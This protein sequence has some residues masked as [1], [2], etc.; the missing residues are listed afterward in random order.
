VI[1]FRKGFVCS[2]C[3]GHAQMPQGE[4]RRCY[5]FL[6]SD[7][8]FAHCTRIECGPIEKC[9]TYAHRIGGCRCGKTHSLPGSGYAASGGAR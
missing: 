6:S 5:G 7:A 1:R 9:G 4:G 8:R 3:G 2:V